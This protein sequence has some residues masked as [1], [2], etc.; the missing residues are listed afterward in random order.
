VLLEA[1]AAGLPVVATAVGGVPELAGDAALLVEAGRPGDA[2]DALARL[3]REPA[4]QTAL[5]ER[6]RRRVRERTLEA[7]SARVARFIAA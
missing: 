4:L 2:A 6:G 1:Y 3:A 5:A 7:E